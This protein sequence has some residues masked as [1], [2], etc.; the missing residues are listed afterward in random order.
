MADQDPAEPAAAAAAPTF[1]LAPG[2][3]GNAFIDYG[4]TASRKLYE[5]AT[6]SLYASEETKY[7]GEE[8]SMHNFCIR[9][10]TH[11]EAFG[12]EHICS[13]PTDPQQPNVD[14]KL[15][16]TGYGQ[17]P[18]EMVRNHVSTSLLSKPNWMTSRK[19]LLKLERPLEAVA[20]PERLAPSAL[21][22]T[23]RKSSRRRPTRPTGTRRR[24][25]EKTSSSAPNTGIGALTSPRNAGPR[26]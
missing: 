17:L 10:I 1:A 16:W 2:L 25:T 6:K 8:P 21:S 24:L 23:G 13:V 20:D 26:V 15:I 3:H 9:G 14:I 18:M 22:P 11:S 5:A 7:D 4:T 19:S 12:W